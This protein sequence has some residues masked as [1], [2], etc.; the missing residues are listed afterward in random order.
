MRGRVAHRARG[1]PVSVVGDHLTATDIAALGRMHV[2]ALPE[3]LV[4]RV[5]ER[6]ARAFYGYL[7]GSDREVVFVERDPLAGNAVVAACIVS[8][9]P[10]TLN[11]RLWWRTPLLPMAVLAVSRLLRRSGPPDLAGETG[12]V[13]PA[14]PEVILIFTQRGLRSRG[15]GARLLTR[16]EAWLAAHGATV[17]YVKTRDAPTNRA[18]GFYLQSGFAV[19]GSVVSKG[20]KLVLFHK[21]IA[22]EQ[23]R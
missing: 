19:I 12:V 9:H 10:E 4:S 5:G 13:Q 16:A 20:K 11:R 6:Y 14:G 1:H 21:R 17:L 8:L 23:A 15:C 22:A 18:V 2:E 3:S 7:A